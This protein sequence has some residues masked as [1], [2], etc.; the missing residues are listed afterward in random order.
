MERKN[1]KREK[2]KIYSGLVVLKRKFL[3]EQQTEP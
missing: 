1:E 2:E 3:Q